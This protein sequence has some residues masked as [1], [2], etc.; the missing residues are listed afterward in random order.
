MMMVSALVIPA[1]AGTQ[2]N[3]KKNCAPRF[4]GGGDGASVSRA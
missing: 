2:P 1:K 3:E 4:R